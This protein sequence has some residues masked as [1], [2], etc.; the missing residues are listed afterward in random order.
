[1]RSVT[2]KAF[3]GF[4]RKRSRGE[5]R[6]GTSGFGSTGASIETDDS[7]AVRETSLSTKRFA[8]S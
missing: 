7:L 2:E 8:V 3:L 1:M 5:R 4:V 6:S